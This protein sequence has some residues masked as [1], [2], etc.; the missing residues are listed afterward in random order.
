[1]PNLEDLK[2]YLN[3]HYGDAV[4]LMVRDPEADLGWR[5]WSSQDSEALCRWI[6]STAPQN[7][8]T[9]P[10]RLPK[11]ICHNL[12]QAAQMAGVGPQ[13]ARAWLER[14][15]NPLPHIRDGRRIVIPHFMLIRWLRDEAERQAANRN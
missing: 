13:T 4:A 1:M 2:Q 15:E 12:D 6:A 11:R 8:A 9:E 5:A 14:E 3:D 7:G 10:H